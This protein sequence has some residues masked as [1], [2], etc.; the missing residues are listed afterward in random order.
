[1]IRR[2]R[3]V[4]ICTVAMSL[5]PTPWAAD[6]AAAQDVVQTS[7][8]S[9]LVHNPVEPAQTYTVR[10]TLYRPASN[11]A[12][13]S[14]ILA[15]HGPSMGAYVWDFPVE[16]Q[17]YSTALR[18]AARGFPVVT[19]DRLGYGS[20]NRANGRL[21]TV[22]SYAHIVG[23]I[24]GDLRHGNYVA[25]PSDR[26]AYS[27]IALMGHSTGAEI[28]ELAAGSITSVDALIVG[29]YTHAPSDTMAAETNRADALTNEYVYFGGTPGVRQ[30]HLFRLSVVDQPVVER[31]TEL[32]NLV[33]SAELLTLNPQPSRAV[34]GRI[35]VPVLLVLAEN[36]VLYPI[37]GAGA[38]LGL[39]SGTAD[40]TLYRVPVAEH[41]YMLHRNAPITDEKILQW[42]EKRPAIP[43]CA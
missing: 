29:A 3:Q 18:F 27:Q 5:F 43:A 12:C 42:L 41:L 20:S 17:T 24:V 16:P 38:E 19:I 25:P 35:T 36:D 15:V 23:Q 9:F 39:F 6:R 22:P 37:R 33:P 31:E 1:M 14:V 8:I 10:G 30:E 32:A 34:M 26:P 2:R 40:K 7:P 4:A 28:V 21:L 11:P 13:S